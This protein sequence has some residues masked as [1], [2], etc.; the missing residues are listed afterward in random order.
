MIIEENKMQKNNLVSI[1]ILITLSFLMM[2]CGGAPPFLA[3]NSSSPPLIYCN[4]ATGHKTGATPIVLN[5][6]CTCTPTENHY[7]RCLKEGTIN[8]TL[9]YTQFLELY[10]SKGIKTDLDH[11]GC[12]NRCQWGPH[13]VF[14]GKCMATP[15]PGTLNYEK[16]ISGI[17]SLTM[18]EVEHDNEN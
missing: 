12:N 15:T 8:S 7:N 10:T 2:S 9:I 18:H 13:V 6:A 5:G 4:D 14:G 16:V 1:I 3:R 11:R 17:Q